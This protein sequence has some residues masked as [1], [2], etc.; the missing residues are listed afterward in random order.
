MNNTQIAIKF[1]V[2]SD[3]H[4]LVNGESQKEGFI[5]CRIYNGGRYDTYLRG[6]CGRHIIILLEDGRVIKTNDLWYISESWT[7]SIYGGELV[8]KIVDDSREV[9]K[10]LDKDIHEQFIF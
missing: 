9:P 4:I 6:C 1:Y 8:G 10:Y 7:E 5:E 2:V 3:K